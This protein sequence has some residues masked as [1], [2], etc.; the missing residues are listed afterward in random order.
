[1]I[2]LING[3]HQ[4]DDLQWTLQ[5]NSSQQVQTEVHTK[6]KM[7][8][9]SQSCQFPVDYA[10][11]ASTHLFVFC[12]GGCLGWSRAERP[13]VSWTKVS[14][15]LWS[16]PPVWLNV[17]FMTKT[18][19][20]AIIE[21]KVPHSQR[22]SRRKPSIDT[23][24]IVEESSGEVIQTAPTPEQQ[25]K[26]HRWTMALVKPGEKHLC[27][28]QCASRKEWR[29][30]WRTIVQIIRNTDLWDVK[31]RGKPSSKTS[32]EQKLRNSGERETAPSS[33]SAQ[34]ILAGEAKTA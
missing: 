4:N 34:F 7:K 6:H 1:M 9:Q 3:T 24:G 14:K 21:N 22:K 19:K 18:C 23:D 10:S 12:A 16:N 5:S 27:Q 13:S 20:K 17:N 11:V 32:R 28:S 30:C 8:Q 26:R 2:H 31:W 25:M 15:T 29:I 33:E